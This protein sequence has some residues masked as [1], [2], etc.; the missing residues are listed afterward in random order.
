MSRRTTELPEGAT[1]ISRLRSDR[2]S[3]TPKSRQTESSAAD[4]HSWAASRGGGFPSLKCSFFTYNMWADSFQGC[5]RVQM[6]L[7]PKKTPWKMFVCSFI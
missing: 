6:R 4:A 3:L 7:P 5:H 2:G 1:S